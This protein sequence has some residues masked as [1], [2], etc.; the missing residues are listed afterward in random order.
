MKKISRKEAKEKKLIYY[1]TGIPCIN[2]HIS[3]RLTRIYTC[4]ECELDRYKIYKKTGL[5]KKRR[6]TAKKNIKV[7]AENF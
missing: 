2:G 3:K 5:G 4:Y 7:V 1:Y 6:K